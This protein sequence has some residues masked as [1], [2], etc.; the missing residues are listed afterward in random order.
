MPGSSAEVGR[1]KP[2]PWAK[3]PPLRAFVDAWFL[4]VV[5]SADF[6]SIGVHRGCACRITAASPAMWG[7]AIEVPEIRS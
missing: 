3:T 1:T 7:E 6:T 2:A 4:A 5:I